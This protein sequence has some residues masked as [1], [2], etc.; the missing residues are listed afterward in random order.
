MLKYLFIAEKPSVMNAVKDTYHRHKAD[1]ANKIGEIEFTALSGHVC[2]YL[3]PDEYSKWKG[4][5]W[6]EIDLPMIPDPF[7]ITNI[8]Q[9][10]Q[11]KRVFNDIRDTLKNGNFD[12][13]IVGT[14]SDVEG[15]GIY[16]LLSE[17]L[18]LGQYKTLRYFEASL[19]DAEILKSLYSMTE[20]WKDP[21]DVHMTQA[22][23]VRSHGDWL[24]GMN[25]TRSLTV[26]MGTLMR[27]GRVKAP[28]LRLV[29]LNSRA[30]DEFKPHSDF[31]AQ[32][33]YQEGFTGIYV[34]KDGP[35]LYDTKE[36][37]EAFLVTLRGASTAT[38]TDINRKAVKTAAP[39]LYKL[40]TIQGE[41][42]SKYNYSPQKTLDTIQTLYE[43]KL[44]SYPRTDGE[45]V[46]TDKAK[47][48]E[49]LL[50]SASFVP[51]LAPY[52]ANIT[53]SDIARV[54]G[55]KNVVNDAEVQKK[56]HDALLPTENHP[57]FDSLSDAEKNIYDMICRRLT[58]QFLP[59]LLEEKTVLI[60]DIKNC[61]FKSNGTSIKE[62]G[63]SELYDR[64]TKGETI[65]ANINRGTVLNIKNM[66]VHEKKS[67]PPKRLTEAS[68]ITAMENIGKYIDDKMLKQT[69]DKAQG[70]GQP[71]TRAAII[72]AL[73]DTGYMESKGKTNQLFITELGIR[74]VEAIANFTISD[75]VQAAQWENLFQNVREGSVAYA[76]AEQQFIRYVH[77]FVREVGAMQCA[78]APNSI[79][80]Y[81]SHTC[82]YCGKPILKF[83]W[84]YACEASKDGGCNF[85]VG[86][87]NGQVKDSDMDDLL[88]KGET[89]MFKNAVKS[90]KTGKSYDAKMKLE[91]KGSQFAVRAD[92]GQSSGGGNVDGIACPYCG[93]TVHTA[94]W[95]YACEDYKKGCN[96]AVSSNNGK[97]KEKDLKELITKKR[98]RVFRSW[99]KSKKT[100]K[101]YD[102][103]LELQPKGSTYATQMKFPE[104]EN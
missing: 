88:T 24:V 17:C 76:D 48:F 80:S 38:V 100:G 41:A 61:I 20:F 34:T 10:T 56:S 33:G 18:K 55:N 71:S 13:I 79:H 63:W 62:K 37:A 44:V 43:K 31:L 74:Y 85:K 68:L 47:E 102:A 9:P 97:L 32:V 70:L 14:D 91:P 86:N 78:P 66:Q 23:L 28:T 69:M 2:R 67:T 65:P 7:L 73:L 36:K 59:E 72:K 83:K 27:V 26:K 101:P 35:V 52:I 39:R 104:R 57:D 96:F 93:K 11:K 53:A 64:Q 12:G 15:N 94:S 3:D 95:G 98:T 90:Q 87:L 60:T 92:F 42:G 58:A 4:Q 40:S 30:I 45:Y 103:Y 16:Y 5:R 22:Y 81:T 1:I 51:A 75:P 49:A 82:P 84:G 54:R 19:T 29:Y 99:G 25:A 77:D 8:S 46:S 89:R 6:D 50:T 21:R